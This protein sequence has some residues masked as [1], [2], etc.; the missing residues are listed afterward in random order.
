MVRASVVLVSASVSQS[1]P[2]SSFRPQ[3]SSLLLC[4]GDR[5]SNIGHSDIPAGFGFEQ[6]NTTCA[7]EL[8]S[9]QSQR[10]HRLSEPKTIG[11][12]LK[13]RRLELHLFQSDLA[14]LF[15]VD[16]MSIGNWERNAYQLAK[17]H[18]SRIIDWL[19]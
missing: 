4:C 16:I 5:F 12:R 19:G 13:R 9:R 7:K 2:A 14:K 6:K 1:F 15:G 8:I 3:P 17:R 10:A 18:M 11:D